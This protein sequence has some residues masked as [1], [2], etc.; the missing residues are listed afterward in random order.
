MGWSKITK[1]EPTLNKRKRKC[2]GVARCLSW[3]KCKTLTNECPVEISWLLCLC[4]V[5]ILPFNKQTDTLKQRKKQSNEKDCRQPLDLRGGKGVS[6][7]CTQPAHTP[8]SMLAS[9][10][11]SSGSS[12][13]KSYVPAVFGMNSQTD[14]LTSPLSQIQTSKQNLQTND[15]HNNRRSQTK[16]M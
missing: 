5:N 16:K 1:R 12:V 2:M 14:P 10:D 15:Q 6:V 7:V 11:H 8:L 3:W 4:S 9:S 13:L